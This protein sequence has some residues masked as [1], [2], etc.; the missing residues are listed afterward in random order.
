[1]IAYDLAVIIALV[2]FYELVVPLVRGV[3]GLGK[4]L[5][6]AIQIALLAVGILIIYHLA[7][8]VYYLLK[9]RIDRFARRFLERGSPGGDDNC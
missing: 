4:P 2:L 7:N 9:D 1:M 3:G 8:Q 5:S 6:P